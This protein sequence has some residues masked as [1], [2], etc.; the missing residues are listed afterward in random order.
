[1]TN[2]INPELMRIAEELAYSADV[3]ISTFREPEKHPLVQKIATALQRARNDALEDAAKYFE[4][5]NTR[6]YLG[7]KSDV[8]VHRSN[9]DFYAKQFRALKTGD[10]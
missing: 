7:D 8:E 5:P 2:K 1:M 3:G 9:C 6:S 10:V 4:L